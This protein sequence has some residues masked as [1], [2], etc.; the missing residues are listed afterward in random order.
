VCDI[1][2]SVNDVLD[3]ETPAAGTQ[4]APASA[5]MNAFVTL[6]DAAKWMTF[7]NINT[8]VVEWDYVRWSTCLPSLISRTF[9]SVL[10][11]FITFPASQNEYASVCVY[12]YSS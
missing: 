3:V 6:L 8:S 11:R 9:Q 1:L 7:Q 2:Y 4:Y 10:G 5:S 12:F